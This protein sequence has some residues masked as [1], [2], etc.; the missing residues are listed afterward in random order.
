MQWE[1]GRRR[2]RKRR[3]WRRRWGVDAM[4]RMEGGGGVDATGWKVEVGG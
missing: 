4:G 3:R 1:K 2:R